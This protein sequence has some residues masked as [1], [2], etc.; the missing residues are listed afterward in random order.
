MPLGAAK[1]LRSDR[2]K[3]PPGKSRRL[4]LIGDASWN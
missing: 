4:S 2:I 3:A 1:A